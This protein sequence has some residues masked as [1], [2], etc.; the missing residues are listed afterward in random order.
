MDE[1]NGHDTLLESMALII[2][3]IFLRK[4]PDLSSSGFPKS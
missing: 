4:S 3:D 1:I 2:S